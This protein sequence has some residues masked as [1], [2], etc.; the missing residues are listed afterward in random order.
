MKRPEDK[1]FNRIVNRISKIGKVQEALFPEFA[2]ASSEG[3]DPD[4]ANYR[5]LS[6]HQRDFSPIK[7]ER[8]ITISMYLMETN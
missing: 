4:E 8:A 7:M 1:L 5:R 2:Q 3:I 6:D